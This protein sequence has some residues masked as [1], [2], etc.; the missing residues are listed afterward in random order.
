M[1]WSNTSHVLQAIFWC[2]PVIAFSMGYTVG[3]RID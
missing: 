3:N 2:V 1:D